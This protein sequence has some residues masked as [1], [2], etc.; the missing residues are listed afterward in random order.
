MP[1]INFS[2]AAQTYSHRV[3]AAIKHAFLWRVYSELWQRDPST[4]LRVFDAEIDDGGF[5]VVLSVG[6]CMRHL[7]LKCSMIGSSTRSVVLR[8]SLCELPGGSVVWMEYVGS[9]LEIRKYH[10]F[11]FSN[12]LEPLSFANFPIARTVRADSK[13]VKKFRQSVHVVP[14]TAFNQDLP[15]DAILAVLFNV[16]SK[17]VST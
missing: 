7:Q 6:R 17:N 2:Q 14:K 11:A 9:T 12:P 10:L 15:F 13:G 5:D 16:Q 1:A 8:Q 3:E 4:K